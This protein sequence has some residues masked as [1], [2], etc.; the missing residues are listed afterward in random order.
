MSIRRRVSTLVT[1]LAAGLGAVAAV[2]P[3]ATAEL[4]TCTD[5][6]LIRSIDHPELSATVP[7]I[8]NQTGQF[9]CQLKL[10]DFNN[11]AVT[12]LQWLSLN[13][14]HSAGLNIDGDYGMRTR[15]IVRRLQERANIN[16]D[17]VYGPDTRRNALRWAVQDKQG[18]TR[19]V[20]VP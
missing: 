10:N 3:P 20:R 11:T 2:A 12:V 7:S 8:G 18:I 14:C 9:T 5:W 19:C 15:E 13:E 4:P 16:P 1:A 6:S 17:G